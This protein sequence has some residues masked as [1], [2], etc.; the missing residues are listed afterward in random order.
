MMCVCGM[1]VVCIVSCSHLLNEHTKNVHALMPTLLVL[2]L[3]GEVP[4]TIP[5]TSPSRQTHGLEVYNF[6]F[7]FLYLSNDEKNAIFVE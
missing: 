7:P 5:R 1:I 2:F 6:Y 3:A 4:L